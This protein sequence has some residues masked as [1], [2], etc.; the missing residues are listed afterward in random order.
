MLRMNAR[1]PLHITR[2]LLTHGFAQGIVRY[3]RFWP[4]LVRLVPLARLTGPQRF[5]RLFEDLGGSF[6]KFGQMLAL[7]S[8]IV[9]LEY[10]DELFNLIDRI[11]PFAYVHVEETFRE[12]LGKTPD[13]LID[14]F[15]HAPTATAS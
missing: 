10:C 2:V 4:W 14:Q 11:A 9:S 1:R 7:Q 3:G 12:E 6:I 15:D 8:D 13:D 5:R